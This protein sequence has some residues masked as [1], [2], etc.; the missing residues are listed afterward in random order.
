MNKPQ[1]T[2]KIS[3]ELIYG[4]DNLQHQHRAI[5]DNDYKLHFQLHQTN[6]FHIA[7]LLSRRTQYILEN[8][9]RNTDNV[10]FFSYEPTPRIF[11]EPLIYIY[12]I[13]IHS[14][15]YYYFHIFL[16]LFENYKF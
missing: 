6:L 15:F 1:T 3:H 12:F 4:D 14:L 2:E 9:L 7:F 5:N 8:H 10:L 16:S 11:Y 13:M